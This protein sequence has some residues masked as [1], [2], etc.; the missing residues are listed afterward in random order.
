MTDTILVVDDEAHNLTLIDAYLA[1]EGYDLQFFTD[2]MLALAHLRGG[3]TAHAVLLDRMMP[4]V[5]GLTVLKEIRADTR[6][7]MLP[8]IMQTAAAS[9][10]QIAEGIAAG[11][12]YYLTKPFPREVLISVLSRALRDY[13]F[14]RDEG[15]TLSAIPSALQRLESAM[16]R[17]RTLDDVR[18]V[19]RT[20]AM[21]FA[22]DPDVLV[23]IR[24]LMVNAVEHGNLGITYEEKSKLVRSGTWEKEIERRLTLPEYAEKS[25]R[26]IIARDG[27][28]L[29]L[30]IEDD[31]KGFD[32]ERYL[33]FDPK[34][35]RDIHGR[36]IAMSSMVSF[37][38]MY[39]IHPGNKVVC[40]K[41][42]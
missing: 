21:L 10:A 4:G 24:E 30:T 8:V 16:F 32:W 33:T 23:G 18:C 15:E 11:A 41:R 1:G 19:A 36:G 5:D 31:G 27:N 37:D 6:F 17:F 12:Y 9:P 40:T 38:E 25:A 28:S 7:Q 34:R 22:D 42:T 39:F 3:G 14:H 20:I 13:A 2:P 26:A 29:A 35:A